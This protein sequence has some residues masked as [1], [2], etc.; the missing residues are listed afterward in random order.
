MT[1]CRAIRL[2]L[3]IAQ[4]LIWRENIVKAQSA[5]PLR[6]EFK[7][8]SHVAVVKG[9]L[10]GRQQMEYVTAIR[11]DQLV[12]LRLS[13]G[14]R[15]ALKVRLRDP[16]NVDVVLLDAGPHRWTATVSETGDYQIW[17]VRLNNTAG[18]S[19]YKLRITI[20]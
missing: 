9:S 13:N 3:V 11:K 4:L 16:H 5:E 12:T 6:V 8:G 14:S 18:E 1:A 10:Q 2:L 19:S 17:V 7:F 15:E 20:R